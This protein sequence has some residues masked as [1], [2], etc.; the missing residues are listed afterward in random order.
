MNPLSRMPSF[1]HLS[2]SKRKAI[3]AFLKS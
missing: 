2:G 1:K 3:V